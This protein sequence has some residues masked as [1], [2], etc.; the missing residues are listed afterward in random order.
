MQKDERDS[1][2]VFGSFT[3]AVGLALGELLLFAGRPE[4]LREC[5]VLIETAARGTLLASD[6]EARK[7]SEAAVEK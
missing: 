4:A 2:L 6:I 7:R 1:D 5:L 3:S